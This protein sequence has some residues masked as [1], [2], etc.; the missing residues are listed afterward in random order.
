MVSFYSRRRTSYFYWISHPYKDYP[1]LIYKY[2]IGEKFLNKITKC[3][4]E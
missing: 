4:G 1:K 2:V 3:E